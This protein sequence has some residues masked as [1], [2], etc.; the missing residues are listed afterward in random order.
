MAH[1]STDDKD[2]GKIRNRQLVL[3]CETVLVIQKVKIIII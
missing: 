2:K 1:G 3:L